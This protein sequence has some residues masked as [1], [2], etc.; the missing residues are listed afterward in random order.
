EE[1]TSLKLKWCRKIL[2]GGQAL[3]DEIRKRLFKKD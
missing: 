3:E 1:Q 2:N